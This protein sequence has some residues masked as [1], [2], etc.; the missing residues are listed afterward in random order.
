MERNVTAVVMSRTP[1]RR[2]FALPVR[3][4]VGVYAD[5]AGM[6]AARLRSLDGVRTPWCCWVDD[7]DDLPVGVES[8]VTEC[9][10]RANAVGAA[11]VYT[12]ELVND[13]QRQ[14]VR[15]A[16]P[17]DRAKH[18]HDSM[19]VHHLALMRTNAVR[20]VVAALPPTGDLWA[21]LAVYY[22]LGAVGAVAV[23]KIGYKWN[24]N[25]SG[26]HHWPDMAHVQHN[27]R[28]MLLAR[29]TAI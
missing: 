29:D 15:L 21:E 25:D 6:Y 20:D 23:N 10:E 2:G 7:D 5:H 28:R 27:T 24:V 26:V 18:L 3:N 22:G 17:Y 19:F 16:R 1:L 14:Y 11:L 9:I 12:A 13:S 4:V 8:L